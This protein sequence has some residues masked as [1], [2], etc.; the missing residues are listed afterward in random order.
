MGHD[1]IQLASSGKCMDALNP[2]LIMQKACRW[3][4]TQPWLIGREPNTHQNTLVPRKVYK[5]S[6]RDRTYVREIVVPVS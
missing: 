2:D 1:E 6:I 5:K 3:S 4:A